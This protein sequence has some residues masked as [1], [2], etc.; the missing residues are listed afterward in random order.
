MSWR[1][2]FVLLISCLLLPP[3][4]LALLWMRPAGVIKKLLGTLAIGAIAV[5][6]LVLLFGLR[7]EMAGSGIRPMFTFRNLEKHYRRIEQS[8]ALQAAPP[9]LAAAEP[10]P[11]P[12]PEVAA[13]KPATVSYWTDF[14]GP[15]RDGHYRQGEILTSWP[16]SGLERIWKQPVG[17]GYASFAIGEGRAYTIEQRRDK[18]FIAAY[19]LKTG[20]ELWT[21]SYPASFQESMGGDGPR[22]TPTYHEGL[23]YALGAT[24]E[25]RVL[26][27]TTGAVKWSKNILS[28]NQAEN[29][30]WGMAAAPLIVE[31]K[32]IVQ[33]GGSAGKSVVAYDKLTGRRI[34]G[35]LDDK[36]AYTSPI[37]VHLA[38]K[39]QIL[40]VTAQR[41]VGLAIEDGRL[42]WEYPWVTEYDV[43]A[44]QPVVVDESRFIL[45]AGYGHGASLVEIASSGG[46]F[47]ARSVWQNHRM[48]NRFNSSVLHQGHIYGLDEGIFACMRVSD[49]ALKWKSGRYGYG[50]TLLASGHIVV[51]TESGE[52]ALVKPDPEKHLELARFQAIEGK[53]W[54]VPAIDSGYLLVRNTSDMACFRIGR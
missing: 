12:T 42:L 41:A 46:A 44:S 25:F 20:L 39:R 33:P 14:R 2:P 18:E 37:I 31:E 23:V 1:S 49:G 16:S 47:T 50:Q 36:Q 28:D 52:L 6:H 19:D 40:T 26:D 13:A 21:H 29:I 5:V 4:G 17:G 7:M 32:V 11:E 45:S 15:L 51:L 8:R 38:G 3:L 22:A 24:G 54:N 35:S 53:T 9:A 27:A 43:N 30:Q 34:W 10:A 48:K